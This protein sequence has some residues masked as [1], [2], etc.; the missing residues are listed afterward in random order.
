MAKTVLVAVLITLVA[1]AS[2]LSL[3]SAAQ[4]EPPV[5]V[6]TFLVSFL[7]ALAGDDGQASRALGWDASVDPC[8]WRG[9]RCDS[10]RQV[11]GIFLEG[12]RGVLDLN[13]TI[14]ATLLC[15][16][17]PALRVVSLRG[18]S[19]RGVLPASIA[20][21]AGLR[22]LSLRDNQLSGVL[23]ASLSQLT[24]LRKLDVSRNSFAGELPA[25]LSELRLLAF[26][27]N[28][29]RFSGA[30][31][32]FDLTKFAAFNVS[33]NSL[34]GPIPRRTGHFGTDSFLPNAAGLC[35]QPLFAPCPIS[36]VPQPSY[37]DEN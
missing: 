28:D 14:D 23:P 13:G 8:V 11:L 30:I 2:C 35:G 24:N 36:P 31:P 1:A 37:S 5:S 4:G 3:S 17:A 20:G 18:N 16:A 33:N 22:K 7:H 21:C 26:L 27:A 34:T 15:A 29:N 25:G 32:D 12:L 19:I 6:R 9:V 10:S